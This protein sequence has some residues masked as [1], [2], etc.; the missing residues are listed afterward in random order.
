M[1]LKS[2]LLQCLEISRSLSLMANFQTLGRRVDKNSDGAKRQKFIWT[3]YEEARMLSD[4][5]LGQSAQSQR[6]M[7]R[8]EAPAV[9]ST[10]NPSNM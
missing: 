7:S 3:S 4:N 2:N 6:L 5:H 10:S 9:V 8:L 1:L